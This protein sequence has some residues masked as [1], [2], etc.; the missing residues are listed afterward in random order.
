MN[1][2][3]VNYSEYGNTK[4]DCYTHKMNDRLNFTNGF[5]LT[6]TEMDTKAH[7]EVSASD[8]HMEYSMEKITGENEEGIISTIALF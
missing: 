6:M 8:F 3:E 2:L 1:E 5:D 4:I 7:K